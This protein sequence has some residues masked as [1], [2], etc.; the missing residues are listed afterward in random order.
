VGPERKQ[1]GVAGHE[2]VGR[3]VDRDSE[4]LVI[5]RISADVRNLHWMNH[6]GNCFDFGARGS[7]ASA[8]P[9]AGLDQH[10]FELSEDHV[11]GHELVSATENVFQNL[12]RASAE[13]ERRDEHVRVEDDPHSASGPTASPATPFHLPSDGFLRQSDRRGTPLTVGEEPVPALAAL[14]V[15][16]KRLA[17]KLTAGPPLLSRQTIDLGRKIGRKR[18]RHRS[19]GS[20]SDRITLSLTYCSWRVQTGVVASAAASSR[21]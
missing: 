12:A 9:A 19:C 4:Y 3:P 15:L 6:V 18:D 21:T 10:A 5:V 20:H 2:R 11:A 16:A 17:E 7:C 13:V 14:G 1:V 8:F